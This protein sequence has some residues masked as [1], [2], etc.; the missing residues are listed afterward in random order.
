MSKY[1]DLLGK[2]EKL[3]NEAEEERKKEVREVIADIKTK[4][5]QYDIT[6]SDLGLTGAKKAAS[7]TVAPKYRDPATGKTW[8]GR[9]RAPKW[10]ADAESKGKSRESFRI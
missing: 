10:I 1:Q 2:I 3:K 7:K 5:K 6:A 9:G 8:T 4:I